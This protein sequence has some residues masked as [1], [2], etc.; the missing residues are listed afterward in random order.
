MRLAVQSTL[1]TTMI[2]SGC[3]NSLYTARV[4]RVSLKT[5][6]KPCACNVC[7]TGYRVNGKYCTS[8]VLLWTSSTNVEN[9]ALTRTHG[10]LRST[11]TPLCTYLGSLDLSPHWSKIYCTT[12]G[13]IPV[14]NKRTRPDNHY[15]FPLSTRSVEYIERIEKINYRY[16]A[17]EM[18]PES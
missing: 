8:Y 11:Y 13:Y 12:Y 16:A 15:F 1:H 17:P 14:T 10:T 2:C 18:S 7:G 6:T 5:K 4:L 9:I 3:L